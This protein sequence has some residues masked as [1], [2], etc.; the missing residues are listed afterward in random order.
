M[1]VVSIVTPYIFLRLVLP[2]VP[3]YF[4]LSE[5]TIFVFVF[6][7]HAERYIFLIKKGALAS[8]VE[9]QISEPNGFAI[10]SVNRLEC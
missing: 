3:Q 8:I 10:Y 6:S 1:A 4:R 7:L 9:Y 5:S 2:Q